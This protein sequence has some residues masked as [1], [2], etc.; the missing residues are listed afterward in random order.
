MTDDSTKFKPFDPIRVPATKY[1]NTGLIFNFQN[2][3]TIT[4][5]AERSVMMSSKYLESCIESS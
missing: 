4:M 1:P 2:S 3:T 5:A